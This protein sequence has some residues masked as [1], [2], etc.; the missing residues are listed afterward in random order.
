M[1]KITSF[2][3]ASA[4][5]LSLASCGGT[6]EAQP[7]NSDTAGTSA[8]ASQPASSEA[9]P[10]AVMSHA[11][12]V[13]AALDTQVTVETF[14]QAKQS[15]WNGKATFYTQA[16]DGAYFIYEMPCTEDEYSKLVPGTKIR[17]TGKKAE[18]SG[19]TEIT[20]A[21]YE[22]LEG[23]FVAEPLDVTALL[24]TEQL[25][26]H[27]NELVWFTGMTVVPIVDAQGNEAAFL[28]NDDG[29][30]SEGSDLYFAATADGVTLTFTVESYLC[31]PDTEVYQAVKSLKIGDEV[32]LTAF[33]YWYNGAN[34]HVTELVPAE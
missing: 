29:T 21:I 22:I 16:E 11:E 26:D 34:P 33:L 18:W 9:V 27:Q 14:V 8:A 6:Q 5:M 12:Y 23:Q 24:A 30:G 25:A 31:G 28:Y 19:E 20:D 15:W 17:V 3:L 7:T 4:L 32:D 10:V 13:A 1:K 2:L